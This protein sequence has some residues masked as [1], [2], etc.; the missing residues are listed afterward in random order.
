MPQTQQPPPAPARSGAPV[1]PATV[2]GS[3]T[4]QLAFTSYLRVAAITS[5]VLIHTAG[6]TYLDDD[7]R[8][9]GVWWV[10]SLATF[11]TKWAVPVFVMVS[12]ALLLRA[13]ADPS[14]TL[15]YRR[16]LTRIGIPLVVWHVVYITLSATIL[17]STA[18]PKIIVARFLRGQSYTGLYFF[19]LILG[20]YLIT[21][22]LW[23]LVAGISRRALGWVGALLVASAAANQSALQ[24]IGRLE[25]VAGPT[26]DPSLFTQFVPYLGFFILGYALRDVTIRGRG[27]VLALAALT[28][29]LCLE[30]TWQ[31]TG[32]ARVFGVE[33]ANRLNI[34]TPVHYQGWV[35]GAAAVAVFVLA[36]SLVHPQSRFAQP[37]AARWARTAGD[38]TLGVFAS[39]LLVL[40]I[41]MRIPAYPLPSGAKTP[42]QLG[43][44]CAATLIGALGL[45]IIL[46]RI[47]LLRRS[48]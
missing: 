37:R 2:S 25:G 22:L 13:P 26:G 35:L 18:H 30:L 12:G 24:V 44:L 7:L 23:P 9:A 19:W 1:V 38:L 47:P 45:T 28:T 33:T 16:R 31:A 14:A 11:S 5:V 20:L 29:A 39:H 21:P 8:P 34:L 15:F 40:I 3:A 48:V 36:R 41:L 27:R 43:A 10:A 46:R 42:V 32:G 6:L 4:A 17:V